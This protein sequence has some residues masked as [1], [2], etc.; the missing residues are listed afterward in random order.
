MGLCVPFSGVV[1]GGYG[2]S[3]LA[4]GR[5]GSGVYGVCMGGGW[6]AGKMLTNSRDLQAWWWGVLDSRRD[7]CPEEHQ[8]MGV[9]CLKNLGNFGG[10]MG[11]EQSN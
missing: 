9:G 1:C 8:R 6:A 3:V 2:F 11:S 4:V 5:R 10:N 7:D